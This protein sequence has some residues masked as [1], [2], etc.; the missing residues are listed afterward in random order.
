MI[1]VIGTIYHFV[2]QKNNLLVN[3][4]FTN[5][6]AQEKSHR[7]MTLSQTVF[8]LHHLSSVFEGGAKTGA[9]LCVE[10]HSIYAR[11]VGDVCN[12]SLVVVCK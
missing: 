10:H 6:L 7:W 4:K 3:G 1:Y 9:V 2:E 12:S 8:F 11:L 5:F